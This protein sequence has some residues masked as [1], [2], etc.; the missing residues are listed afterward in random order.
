M[1]LIKFLLGNI[2]NKKIVV[3][4]IMGGILYYINQNAPFLFDE[5]IVILKDSITI[6]IDNIIV[7]TFLLVIISL[8]IILIKYSNQK[9]DELKY[10][11]LGMK[12]H[13]SDTETPFGVEIYENIRMSKKDTWREIFFIN[14]SG[15]DLD[16]VEGQID[17]YDKK[18]RVFSIPFTIYI[19]KNGYG[20]KII[21]QEFNP[22]IE[23]W[24]EYDFYIKS[25]KYGE[26]FV[27]NKRF[28]GKKYTRLPDQIELKKWYQ[29]FGRYNL[30]WI[31][32]QLFNLYLHFRFTLKNEGFLKKLKLL[33]FS[34]IGLGLFGFIIFII[35]D[36]IGILIKIISH[37]YKSIKE[38][39]SY[40]Q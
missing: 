19:L 7:F 9:H 11:D 18:K 37:W 26:D 10:R 12:I 14:N 15:N 4:L 24:E 22:Y 38:I 27:S 33:V 17:F 16:H 1:E 25:S 6:F 21:N 28:C 3:L 5:L 31:Y 40:Y 35:V 23:R 20:H 34:L 39:W 36:S 32:E 30:K 29:S 8:F 2:K 13:R